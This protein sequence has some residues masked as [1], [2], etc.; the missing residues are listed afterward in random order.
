MS[1]VTGVVILNYN[2]AA[3]TIA[4]INSLYQNTTQSAY[5]I[6]VVD[7]G[8]TPRT[9]ESIDRFIAGFDDH[10][11]LDETMSLPNSLPFISHLRLSKNL[12]YACGNNRAIELFYAD[13]DVDRLLIL[14]NDVLLTEDII[15]PL[16]ADLDSLPDAAIVTPLLYKSDG[17]TIDHNCARRAPRLSEI[18]GLWAMLY[19]TTFGIMNR[20]Y[21]AQYLLPTSPADERFLRVELPSGSCMMCDKE[22]FRKIGSFDP[23]TFLY[24]EENILWE[25]IRPLDLHNYLDKHISCIHLG[26]ATTKTKSTSSFIARSLIESTRYFIRRYTDAGVAY[27]AGLELFFALFR[28]KVGIKERWSAKKQ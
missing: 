21:Q 8:S 14:N 1:H 5:K 10:A 16:N 4:C 6:V 23:N 19:R 24:Y 9:T 13:K 15:T 11:L 28:M 3:D 26:A 22:L 17:R 7:N 12:G 2:N 18:F 25:K 20:I 27:R